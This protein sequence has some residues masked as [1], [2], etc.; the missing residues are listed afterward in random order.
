[1]TGA[2]MP[3]R[4]PEDRPGDELLRLERGLERL[5]PEG[6]VGGDRGREGAAGA[7]DVRRV[8]PRA[9]SNVT[10]RP[11]KA[12][13]TASASRRRP[14]F[15]ITSCGPRAC[16]SRAAASI[17]SRSREMTAGEQGGLRQVRRH[18]GGLGEQGRDK[19]R[20]RRRRGTS[21]C[22]STRRGRGRRQ[23]AG[24]R[25]R[26]PRLASIFTTPEVASMPVLAART[27]MSERTA[28]SCAATIVGAQG[29]EVPH[30]EGVLGRH[31]RHHQRPEHAQ[32]GKSAQVG[33]EAGPAP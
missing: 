18:D 24:G 15:T 21:A 16:S 3:V 8:D 22:R 20:P 7:V 2:E 31:R 25:R 17:A 28:S 9:R 27:S 19:R 4:A 1:M 14:P 29:Q 30:A 6:D 13:S 23:E 5:E 33:R 12:T 10:Q 32:G 11:S 26:R